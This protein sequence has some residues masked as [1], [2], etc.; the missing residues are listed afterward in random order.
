MLTR[1]MELDFS[2]IDMTNPFGIS[3][4]SNSEDQVHQSMAKPSKTRR[5]SMAEKSENEK[6]NFDK[7]GFK[8]DH[9]DY[10]SKIDQ[11]LKRMG[12]K[13]ADKATKKKLIQKIR[14][15]LS[16]NRSRL[17]AKKEYDFL[18]AENQI[19]KS[20]N[21]KI[22]HRIK[23][24]KGQ[25]KSLKERILD[26]K[27]LLMK[28]FSQ[29]TIRKSKN[30]REFEFLK[31]L[32]FIILISLTVMTGQNVPTE[33]QTP[34]LFTQREMDTIHGHGFKLNQMEMFLVKRDFEQ[35]D[36]FLLKQYLIE[37]SELVISNR[38]VFNKSFPEL[39]EEISRNVYDVYLHKK[40]MDGID[41]GS[42]DTVYN[43]EKERMEEVI[44]ILSQDI[45][46][47]MRE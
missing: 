30:I 17:R 20:F 4:I 3:Y 12:L 6:T 5:Q 21:G 42:L 7:R 29:G 25:N 11:E 2:S 28:Q 44:S 16:A 10:K 13:D 39:S 40:C 26:G 15:R 47:V 1:H 19:L 41:I 9:Y 43:Q 37:M 31:S 46:D 33:D 22:R 27:D 36:A 14:N 23:S 45:L 35:C 38:N 24:F 18:K 34:S 32:F 8:I